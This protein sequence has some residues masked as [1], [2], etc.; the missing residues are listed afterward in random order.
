MFQFIGLNIMNGY[1]VNS[2]TRDHLYNNYEHMEGR[3]K[4]ES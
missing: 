2:F 4:S 1:Y 3:N